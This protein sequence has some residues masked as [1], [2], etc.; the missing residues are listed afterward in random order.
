MPKTDIY[1]LGRAD[2][3]KRLKSALVDKSRQKGSFLWS[4]GPAG[5]LQTIFVDRVEF[6]RAHYNFSMSG[7]NSSEKCD[8]EQIAALPLGARIKLDP[9]NDRVTLMK[10][11]AAAP[12]SAREKMP[13]EV[14]PL[15]PYLTRYVETSAEQP[16]AASN[17]PEL[18]RSHPTSCWD[19]RWH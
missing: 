5:F 7:G 10:A 13:F 15:V 1:F 3:R 18:A 16:A 2:F 4:Y 6:G 17:G 19:P 9:Y 14:T 12:N 8:E 11:R